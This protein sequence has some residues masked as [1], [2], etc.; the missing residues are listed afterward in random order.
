MTHFR[1]MRVPLEYGRGRV[2][3]VIQWLPACLALALLCMSIVYIPRATAWGTAQHRHRVRYSTRPLPSRPSTPCREATGEEGACE[4]IEDTSFCERNAEHNEGNG[5]CNGLDPENLRTIYN[6]P[7]K[8]AAGEIVADVDDFYYPTANEDL[9]AYRARYKLP[10][11]TEE[12][13]CF[14]QVNLKGERLAPGCSKGCSPHYNQESASEDALDLDMISAA[15]DECHILLVDAT[16]GTSLG[17]AEN[18]AVS[19]GA[20]VITN[21]W[22]Y[23]FEGTKSK[24]V[25]RST[26]EKDDRLYFDHPGIPIFFSGGDYGY[27]VRY[28]AVSKYVIAVGGTQLKRNATT[29]GWHEEVWNEPELEGHP[30]T[31]SGCSKW[32]PKPRFQATAAFAA[33]SHRIQ[34]DV[35]ADAAVEHSG[36]STYFKGEFHDV[37]GTSAAAPFWAGVEAL[38][39]A[40]ARE[41]GAEAFYKLHAEPPL[42]DVTEGT[43]VVPG[44]GKCSSPAEDEFFCNAEVG[45]DGPTGWGSPDGV[46]SATS[47]SPSAVTENTSHVKK[48]ETGKDVPYEAT[49]NG[50]VN[51]EGLE[52]EYYFEYGLTTKYGATAPATPSA[53]PAAATYRTVTTTVTGLEP[54]QTYHVRLVA[55]NGD[56][57]TVGE[58]STFKTD[59]ALQPVPKASGDKSSD[60]TGISCTTAEACTAVGHIV[61][62]GGTETPLAMRWSGSA[63]EGQALMAPEDAKQ[64]VLQGVSCRAASECVAT[65]EYET[66]EGTLLDFAETWNGTE[67]IAAYPLSPSGAESTDLVSVSCVAPSFC[68]AAGTYENE[69]YE[70]RPFAET[71][72]GKKWKLYEVPELS[73]AAESHLSSISCTSSAAC[74]AVG[75]Y[76]TTG[77]TAALTEHWNGERWEAQA[78]TMPSGALES[79]LTGVSCADYYCAGTGAYV[80][81]EG[82]DSGFT[83]RGFETTS[84]I[85]EAAPD[86]TGAQFATLT[87]VSCNT[88]PFA[89]TASGTYVSEDGVE[90]TLVEQL[91]G[92]TWTLQTP[93]S[94]AEAMATELTAVS[95]SAKTA[96]IAV[97]GDENGEGALATLGESW[98]GSEWQVQR[99][100][101][102]TGLTESDLA[103]VSCSS[104]ELCRAVGEYRDS[105]GTAFTLAER[106]NGASWEPEATP[107]PASAR[108]SELQSVSCPSVTE[109][110]STGSYVNS[111]DA[112]QDLAERQSAAGWTLETPPIP[113]GTRASELAGVSCFAPV[114]LAVG[115]YKT[116]EGTYLALSDYWNEKNWVE[117]PTA[118]LSAKESS[119]SAVSCPSKPTCMAVGMYVSLAG[120]AVLLSES[121]NGSTKKWTVRYVPSPAEAHGTYLAGV[122]CPSA[123]ECSAVGWYVNREGMDIMLAERWNGKEWAIQTTPSPEKAEASV[124][125]GISCA[126]VAECDAAGAYVNSEG[127][128]VTLSEEW[129]GLYWAYEE[130]FDP[131]EAVSSVLNGISCAETS[132]C[133]AVGIFEGSE[134]HY[135][136]M[137]ESQ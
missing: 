61:N 102:F 69:V 38:D 75:W 98:N 64:A 129:N 82:A 59:W 62:I 57:E 135:L 136:A 47:F 118:A 41:L 94:P 28:P 2:R 66:S 35:A 109:C 130:T 106:W 113:A 105:E 65:G 85:A 104:V 17:K 134:E 133:V 4:L 137:S 95:C 99:T 91:S 107:S 72:N 117:A 92:T 79:R 125:Y 112:R 120:T 26:E 50:A 108:G 49:L 48:E 96:C 110:T 76:E 24:E 5:V 53:I 51:A 80:T 67:W 10:E 46:I 87:G 8:G 123:S 20:S 45:Y 29:R 74:T 63:W 115:R 1:L 131:A 7:E 97:G 40:F 58:D 84:W 78:A 124:L 15:C 73:E 19:L 3:H 11:C 103:A 6:L 12:S 86:P 44:S 30:A 56:G 83:E 34:N 25:G 101:A 111:D 18:E 21:S 52:S 14:R 100:P 116:G 81:A 42:F 128:R 121:W 37:G 71:W 70:H 36:L 55:R 16:G 90:E 32:E 33:C 13:G 93:P 127:S 68:M 77:S 122:S 23:G 89:C 88:S 126:S 22:N 54:N 43:D 132:A 39:S 114:C 27:A 60:L 31:G 9:N 119:L